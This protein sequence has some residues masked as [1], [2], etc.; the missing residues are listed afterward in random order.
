VAD[1]SSPFTLRKRVTSGCKLIC[2]AIESWITPFEK[3]AAFG[4]KALITNEVYG[5]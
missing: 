3:M 4:V 5:N 1:A 2:Q